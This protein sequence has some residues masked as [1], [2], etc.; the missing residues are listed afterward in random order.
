ML[1]IR[2][3]TRVRATLCLSLLLWALSSCASYAP[4]PV[5]LQQHAREFAERLSGDKLSEFAAQLRQDVD[6]SAPFDA[7][8]GISLA[9]ARL[10]ALAFHPDLRAARLQAGVAA[11]TADHAGTWKDPD[12]ALDFTRI[13]EDVTY[14]WLTNS[15]LSLNLPLTGR[16]G[17]E[18]QVATSVHAAM[19]TRVRV[20]E[21][22]VLDEL[23]GAWSEWSA[24]ALRTAQ[25]Q[26]TVEGLRQLEAI[27]DELAE[28]GELTQITAR[29]YQLERLTHELEWS[30][31]LAI[32]TEKL[33]QVERVLGLP[34]QAELT[35]LP[36]THIA[37]RAP[38]PQER[39][40]L[41]AEGP[42]VAMQLREHETAER[43]LELEVR[44]QWPEPLLLGGFQEEDG[45]PRVTFGFAMKLPL[46]NRNK[47]PIAT[48]RAERALAAE[49][50]RGAYERAIQD[51][52]AL[53]IRRDAA[54]AQRERI[55]QELLPLVELQIQDSSRFTEPGGLELWLDALLRADDARTTA[56]NAATAEA[57]ATAAL[58]RLFWPQLSTT[59]REELQ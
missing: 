38:D 19:L 29:L 40:R 18:Q 41:L 37:L 24:A 4:A 16:P 36:Q 15:L 12:L 5:D 9:E 10:I 31:Q 49:L 8:D 27:A 53:A 20:D 32:A 50:V 33:A 23:D 51:L 34:P 47:G 43:N 13:L 6:D 59:T 7:D 56:L 25:L 35:L 58:N 52:D 1:P 2:L 54:L 11:A 48:A 17:L 55:E 26:A 22:E 46:W 21:A 39:Q 42:R 14:P 30:E 28:A 3:P 44:K 45:Q 57:A